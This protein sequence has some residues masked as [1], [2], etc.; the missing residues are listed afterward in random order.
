MGEGRARAPEPQAKSCAGRL[1]ALVPAEG[2]DGCW[3]KPWFLAQCE[4]RPASG[5]GARGLVQSSEALRTRDGK[6]GHFPVA[7]LRGA[8]LGRGQR[9]WRVQGDPGLSGGQ[10]A[11][12]ACI[13]PVWCKGQPVLGRPTPSPLSPAWP[14]ARVLRMWDFLC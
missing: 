4:L 11:A 14:Q 6:W 7:V 9:T 10:E 12:L 2:E 13:E 3:G 8:G 1:A 5:R